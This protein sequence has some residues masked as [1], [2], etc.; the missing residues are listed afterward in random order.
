[1][2]KILQLIED[3]HQIN[4]GYFMLD[5]HMKN[6]HVIEEIRL[7][8]PGNRVQIAM[9]VPDLKLLKID[10]YHEHHETKEVSHKVFQVAWDEAQ[11]YMDRF[12][13]LHE[14][15]MNERNAY[16]EESA[17]MRELW[18]R[19]LKNQISDDDYLKVDRVKK[20]AWDKE[21]LYL[22][23]IFP[24]VHPDGNTDNNNNNETGLRHIMHLGDALSQ[25]IH[26]ML[27]CVEIV[28]SM[29]TGDSHPFSKHR[30]YAQQI[31]LIPGY[32]IK[33]YALLSPLLPE[34]KYTE[35]NDE[36]MMKELLSSSEFAPFVRYTVIKKG[37]PEPDKNIKSSP[38]DS[39]VKKSGFKI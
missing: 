38:E 24:D 5:K 9:S 11:P 34:L 22:N 1:M 4:N 2:S 12:F 31:L 21:I 16:P 13:A 36:E 17:G 29:D 14:N 3:M 27:G 10:F 25:K 23:E 19:V 7:A 33:D 32:K 35:D 28:T 18:E 37:L 26:T 15:A 8:F 6:E 39:A 20:Q 30:H